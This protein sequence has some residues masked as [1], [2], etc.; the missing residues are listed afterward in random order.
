V[1]GSR[2]ADL[3]GVGVSEICGLGWIRGGAETAP[4]SKATPSITFQN[5]HNLIP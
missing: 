1:R 5:Q 2:G 4:T 3:T